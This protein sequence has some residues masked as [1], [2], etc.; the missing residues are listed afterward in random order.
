MNTIIQ[1]IEERIETIRSDLWLTQ[2]RTTRDYMN[3]ARIE[4]LQAVLNKIKET[5]RREVHKKA[6]QMFYDTPIQETNK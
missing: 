6:V 4:E 1:Y 3:L 5:D 2:S